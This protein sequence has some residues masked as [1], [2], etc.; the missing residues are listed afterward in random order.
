MPGAD[1][2]PLQTSTANGFAAAT[3]VADVVGIETAGEDRRDPAAP[4]RDELP[5][6]ARPG[7]AVDA[8]TVG[9]E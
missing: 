8:G 9:V 5:V 3:A 2:T 4:S 7:A 6:E 1:S